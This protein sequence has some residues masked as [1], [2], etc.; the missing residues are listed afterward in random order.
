LT[1]IY[2]EQRNA[3]IL[4]FFCLTLQQIQSGFKSFI[5]ILLVNILMYI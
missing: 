3:M 2:V 1:N 4:S 5:Y